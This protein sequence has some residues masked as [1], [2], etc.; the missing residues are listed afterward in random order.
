MSVASSKRYHLADFSQIA[1]VP[2]PCGSA[3]RAFGDVAEFPGT[4]HVTEIALDARLHYHR[5]LT[6]TYYF[7]ECGDDARMQLDDDVIAVRPGVCVVI[8]PGVRHRALGRMK[9]LIV[10]LPKFD[11]DDEWFDEPGDASRSD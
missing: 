10:V 8:P 2:C 11:P 4:V 3:R 6:E 7:L 1:G 9:V 5:R